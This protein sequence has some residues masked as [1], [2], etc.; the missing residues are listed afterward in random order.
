MV[1][2]LTNGTAYTFTVTATNSVGTG[3]ASAASVAVMP[4][5]GAVSVSPSTLNVAATKA[6]VGIDGF[7]PPQLICQRVTAVRCIPFFFAADPREDAALPI[8]ESGSRRAVYAQCPAPV[9][10]R[11]RSSRTASCGWSLDSQKM[12]HL[13]EA[14]HA[15]SID[16]SAVHSDG[17]AAKSHVCFTRTQAVAYPHQ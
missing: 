1:T 17:V 6:R 13:G 3:A 10:R 15:A 4:I 11:L 12:A 14:G 16:S 8:D 5:G 9:H 2:G 7:A